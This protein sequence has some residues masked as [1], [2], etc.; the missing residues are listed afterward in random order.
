MA[1]L[2][3]LATRIKKCEK[4]VALLNRQP[5]VSVVFMDECGAMI[6]EDGVEYNQRGVLAVPLLMSIAEWEAYGIE[7]RRG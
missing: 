6:F 3:G 5:I 1:G 2:A 7:Q 4:M